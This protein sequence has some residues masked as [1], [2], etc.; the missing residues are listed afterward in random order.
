MESIEVINKGA[1]I[2]HFKDQTLI[3][4]SILADDHE[5][6]KQAMGM[7]NFFSQAPLNNEK[8]KMAALQQIRMFNCIIGIQFKINSNESRTNYLVNT[9]YM[10]AQ[11]L[12]GFVL[13]PNMSLYHNSG[14]LLISIEGSTDYEEFYPEACADILDKM[15]EPTASDIAREKRSLEILEAK[16]IPYMK[17]LKASA[18]EADTELQGKESIIKR[19]VAIYA[20]CVQAEVYTCGRYEHPAEKMAEELKLLEKQ[21]GVSKYFTYEEENYIKDANQYKDKHHLFGWRYECCAVLLW[22]L[23]LIELQEPDNICDASELG[24]I[25]WNNSFESLME[26]SVLRTKEEILDLQDLVFRYNWVCVDARIN[27]R[28]IEGL[29]SSVVYFWHYALNWLLQVDGINDWDEISPNT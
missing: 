13:F 1:F 14:K 25:I 29:D 26:K 8:V 5:T 23:S 9:I 20:T 17:G 24:S 21:Y 19:L 16:G 22:A 7:S 15:I 18:L 10:L 6:F 11:E 12:V 27:G 4:F 2:I 28:E 3:K